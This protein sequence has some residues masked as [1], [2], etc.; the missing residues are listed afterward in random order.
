MK[1]LLALVMICALCVCFAACAGEEAPEA[2]TEATAE[3]AEINTAPF[4]WGERLN[5]NGS[6]CAIEDGGSE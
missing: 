3:A 5:G 4:D 6:G 1:K 2:T